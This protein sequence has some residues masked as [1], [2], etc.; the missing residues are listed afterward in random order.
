VEIPSAKKLRVKT[1]KTF[2]LAGG[3][4]IASFC[5]ERWVGAVGAKL[6]SPWFYQFCRAKARAAKEASLLT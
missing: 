3:K 2:G 4:G 5:H 6:C 1:D